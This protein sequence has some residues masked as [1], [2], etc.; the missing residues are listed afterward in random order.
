M[1]PP[2]ESS[3]IQE[4]E[5]FRDS[6][7]FIEVP[8]RLWVPDADAVAYAWAGRL[9]NLV[10]GRA[11]IPLQEGILPGRSRGRFVRGPRGY[12]RQARTWVKEIPRLGPHDLFEII[13]AGLAGAA[14]AARTEF[15]PN[16]RFDLV[17]A[18]G[19]A[20]SHDAVALVERRFSFKDASVEHHWLRVVKSSQNQGFGAQ[21]IGALLPLYEALGVYQVRL[22]A[23]LS[24]GGAVWGKFGFVPDPDEWARIQPTIKANIRVLLAQAGVPQEIREIC[25]SAAWYANDPHPKN[26]WT[27]SDL[28]GKEQVDG[29]KLGTLL[30]RK[31]RWRGSLSFADPEA[32]SRLKDRLRISG[33]G[34]TALDSLVAAASRS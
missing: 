19:A 27:I 2:S 26:L 10:L 28:A 25:E 7:G 34:S 32:V 16:G 23:G 3:V 33:V 9:H 17:L 24:A 6:P 29:V 13:R 22:T 15:Q 4:F 12:K 18:I 30:L 11:S 21:V 8:F 31:V 5:A 20:D 14:V 1:S